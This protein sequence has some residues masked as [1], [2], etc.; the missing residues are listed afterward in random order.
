MLFPT[1]VLLFSFL[2]S[3]LVGTLLLYLGAVLVGIER[4]SLGKAAVAVLGGGILSIVT[5]LLLFMTPLSF[6][7]PILGIFVS[8]WVVKEVFE[9]SWLKAFLALL[10]PL[11]LFSIVLFLLT[12]FL[13]ISL[14]PAAIFHALF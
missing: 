11:A 7:G 1:S 12:L 13:G 2:V 14:I 5:V 8:I 6:L 4:A 3:L 9:T 10:M